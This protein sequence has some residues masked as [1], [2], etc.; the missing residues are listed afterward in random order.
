MKYVQTATFTFLTA[1]SLNTLGHGGGLDKQGGHFN[2]KTNEY[3]CHREPCRFFSI[4]SSKAVQDAESRGR[5][6]SVLYNRKDWPHWTDDDGDCQNTRAEVL[7][8]HSQLPVKFKRNKGCNVTHGRWYGVYTGQIFTKASDL[9][10]DH[11]VP[12]AHA[13]RQGGANWTRSQK[14]AFAN[15][16]E[17]LLPVEDNAN[18]AKGDKGPDQWKP[19]QK[20]YWCVYARKWEYVKEKYRLGFNGQERSALRE[21]KVTCP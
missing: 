3:H 12:L 1:I 17:N 16:P 19:Q 13:H 15:D 7:I 9:D 10:I 14:R 2:R 6:Y 18:Q 5:A 11:I 20:S 8:A 21:M 4:K